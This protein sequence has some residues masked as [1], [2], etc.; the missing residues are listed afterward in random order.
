M[1]ELIIGVLLSEVCGLL[2]LLIIFMA[3]EIYKFAKNC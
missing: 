1:N 3:V 2:A